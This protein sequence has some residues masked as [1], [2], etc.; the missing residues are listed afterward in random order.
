MFGRKALK[1]RIAELTREMDVYLE[2]LD[3]AEAENQKLE[4]ENAQ[5]LR[6]W[7]CDSATLDELIRRVDLVKCEN[8]RHHTNG[9]CCSTL[10]AARGRLTS[11]GDTCKY[12][13]EP[14]PPVD[15]AHTAAPI[16]DTGVIE[17][18]K[19]IEAGE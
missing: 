6:S 5:L 10:S 13:D 14:E 9:K 7:K 17:A 11:N 2:R 16:D 1:A 4:A 8:C 15:P 19:E 3:K 12:F 18:V